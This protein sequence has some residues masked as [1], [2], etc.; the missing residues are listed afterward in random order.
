MKKAFLSAVTKQGLEELMVAESIFTKHLKLFEDGKRPKI[1]R[2]ERYV[3]PDRYEII[4]PNRSESDRHTSIPHILPEIIVNP[5]VTSYYTADPEKYFEPI[6]YSEYP[7]IMP[8]VRSALRAIHLELMQAGLGRVIQYSEGGGNFFWNR[9]MLL[10]IRHSTVV[11]GVRA[12]ILWEAGI[13][14]HGEDWDF[15]TLSKAIEGMVLKTQTEQL[16]DLPN[17]KVVHFKDREEMDLADEIMSLADEIEAKNGG[18]LE[19]R[20]A[21]DKLRELRD[22]HLSDMIELLFDKNESVRD[23][24]IVVLRDLKN[25]QVGEKIK[26]LSENDPSNLVRLATRATLEQHYPELK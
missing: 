26:W 21:V 18:L 11:E 2:I 19:C 17:V 16:S 13:S 5:S 25:K 14:K 10:A 9:N 7:K 1:L 23:Y 8:Q 22:A 15:D 3:S 4:P 24:M 12:G 6:E 20:E